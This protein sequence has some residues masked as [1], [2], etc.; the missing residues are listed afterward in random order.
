MA[1][2]TCCQGQRHACNHTI[3]F[4]DHHTLTWDRAHPPALTIAPGAR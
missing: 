3:H 2:F 4:H 1:I